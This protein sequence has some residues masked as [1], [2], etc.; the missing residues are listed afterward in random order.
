MIV[1][2][3]HA[4]NDGENGGGGAE[5]GE[6]DFHCALGGIGLLMVLA[7]LVAGFLV[8]GRFGRIA[9]FKP[10]P[11]HKLVVLVMALYLTGEFIYGSTVRNVFFLNSIHGTLGFLTITLAWITLSLNPLSLRKV[12][13]WKIATGAHLIFAS[14]LF[15]MLIIHLSYAF[16]VLGD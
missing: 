9:G 10:L 13:K 4:Q 8:S 16:S 5:S 3:V 7:T 11:T 2:G 12:V 1:T 15:V 14:S 6:G